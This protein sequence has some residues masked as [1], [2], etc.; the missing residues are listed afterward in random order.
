MAQ[1]TI[2][3]STDVGAPVLNGIT[4][5]LITVLDAVLVNGYGA[6]SGAGWT[7]PY[8]SSNNLS[9][10]YKQGAGSAGC[11]MYIQDIGSTQLG[12]TA[13]FRGFLT[14]SS[15]NISSGSSGPFPSDA[16]SALLSHGYAIRKST[17]ADTVARP[18]IIAADSRTMYCF[19]QTGDITAPTQTVV[20]SA[21]MFG[22]I[23]SYVANDPYKCAI[24]GLNNETETG[25]GN[26]QLFPYTFTYTGAVAANSMVIC[27]GYNG[28]AGSTSFGKTTDIVKGGITSPGLSIGNGV[29]PLPNPS[30]G[31][32]YM[33]PVYIIEMSG[34]N[35]TRG[36]L[37]GCWASCHPY[38]FLQ[39]GGIINNIGPENRSVLIV[40]H[41][42]FNSNFGLALIETSNT[43]D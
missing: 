41:I 3:S 32:F 11:Y 2:Y 24:I 16:Q 5:S 25:T 34:T 19:T 15:A 21:V 9:A 33:A 26:A 13:M 37:R 29:L 8:S 28:I 36:R 38:T 30:D 20:Y 4:G 7:K 14:M 18:W 35:I 12:R 43:L 1:F 10:S 17:S 22:D 23:T 6:K 42:C 27:G 40:K 39:D 31:K